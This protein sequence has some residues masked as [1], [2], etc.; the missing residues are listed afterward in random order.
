MSGL[1]E[2]IRERIQALL[3]D[4]RDRPFFDVREAD[5]QARL[6]SALRD[7]VQPSDVEL[8]LTPHGR[9]IHKLPASL[10]TSRVHRELKLDAELKIDIAVLRAN[11]AVE[12]VVH[13]NGPLDII[14]PVRGEDLAAAI[15]IKAAPS[16]NMW[17]AFRDDL[18][19]LSSITA[20]YPACFG[21]FVA[22]DKSLHLGG[23][24]SRVQPCEKWLESLV[25]DPG[26]RV[27]AHW[28][29]LDGQPKWR[30]GRVMP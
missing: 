24:T 3:Q 17:G 13:Q 25:E 18:A 6:F 2:Q 29:T 1:N 10:R 26:G 16:R 11:G 27:E 14:A 15:E 21:F 23:A 4:F 20:A 22:L 28:L 30:R 12:F 8:T 19:K 9:Q 5:P 7:C